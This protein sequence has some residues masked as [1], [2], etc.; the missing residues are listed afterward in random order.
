MKKTFVLLVAA[1]VLFSGCDSYAGA[2]AYGGCQIGSILGSAI[3]GIVGGGRGSDIGAIVG[4][5]GGAVVGGAIGSVADQKREREME[6]CERGRAARPAARPQRDEM[7]QAGVAAAPGHGDDGY[8]SGFDETNSGD[9]RLYDFNSTDRADN[10]SGRQPCARNP[11]EWSVDGIAE[12]VSYKPALEIRDARFVDGNENGVME[13]GEA[14][15]LIFEVINRGDS[16][17]YDL[18]PTVVEASGNRDIYISPSAR[19]ESV[20]PGKGIRYTAFV[21]AGPR[22]RTGKVKL[23]ASVV[24]GSKAIS[25]VCEFNI[26][27]KR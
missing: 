23:R 4:M 18:T 5:A 8:G 12:G 11:Q 13:R 26:P 27:T 16:V 9:D 15:K 10:Y 3:G 17:L 2:G 25:R 6:A 1:G 21:Q 19:V 14:C 7:Y 20:M 22:L 24:Q